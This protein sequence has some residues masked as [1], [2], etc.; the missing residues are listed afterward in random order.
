MTDEE[1]G[2][3]LVR[4]A[5]ATVPVLGVA[6]MGGVFTESVDFS[7]SK[8]AGVICVG[9]GLPPPSLEL[10]LIQAH[11]EESG[12]GR[13]VAYDLPAMTRVLQAAGRILRSA[14]DRGV[15]CLVDARFK[16][17]E[18]QRFFPAHWQP[19]VL[20]AGQMAGALAQ[21]WQQG[22]LRDKTGSDY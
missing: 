8:L 12:R 18:Y 20:G 1:R 3:F 19:T 17:R 11:F 14:E 7:D 15:L 4:F 2:R 21:F 13:E 16:R 22:R 9:I 6:V 5:D 10:G